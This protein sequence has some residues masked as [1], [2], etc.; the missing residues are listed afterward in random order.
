MN[1][2]LL[3]FE[4]DV[5][6]SQFG[7]NMF[8]TLPLEAFVCREVIEAFFWQDQPFNQTRHVVITTALVF[9][10]LIG[11]FDFTSRSVPR[12]SSRSD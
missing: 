2:H 7:A 4:T 12:S 10:A 3:R 1:C 8:A 11:S 6:N 9:N 5:M